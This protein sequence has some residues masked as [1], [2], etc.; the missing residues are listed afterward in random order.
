MI[1]DNREN[2]NKLKL[3]DNLHVLNSYYHVATSLYY[4]I[5]CKLSFVRDLPD[6]DMLDTNRVLV[7]GTYDG[8]ISDM[9]GYNEARFHSADEVRYL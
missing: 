7:A 9:S 5:V 4:V 8:I 2:G 3:P 1:L 6:D